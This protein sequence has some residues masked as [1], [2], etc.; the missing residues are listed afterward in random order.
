M[1]KEQS[2]YSSKDFDQVGS[3]MSYQR[4]ERM[5]HHAVCDVNS[6]RKETFNQERGHGV[7]VV[8]LPTKTI[9]MTIGDLEPGQSTRKHR[10]NYETVIYV[11]QGAGYSLVEGERVD[12]QAG[13]AFYVPVWSWHAHYNSG[14]SKV[15]YVA[16]ENA[17]LLQNLGN[18]AL[19]EEAVIDEEVVV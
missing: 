10:H 2:H 15:V 6:E 3:V 11:T 17:P 8:D 14:D 16:A 5:V 1:K 18:I 19:R 7:H 9:S 12:W 4:P 13:D